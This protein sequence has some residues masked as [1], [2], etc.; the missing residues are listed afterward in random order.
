MCAACSENI[1]ERARLM[2]RDLQPDA[3]DSLK[4]R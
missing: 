1:V 2:K 4:V 3:D